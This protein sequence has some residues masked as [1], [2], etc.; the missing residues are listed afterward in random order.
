VKNA[1]EFVH[2][3]TSADTWQSTVFLANYFDNCLITPGGNE[4]PDASKPLFMELIINYIWCSPHHSK[5]DQTAEKN[6]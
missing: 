6:S 3:R 1:A 5:P 2:H 4:E